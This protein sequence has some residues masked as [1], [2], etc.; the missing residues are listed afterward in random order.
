M[1][2]LAFDVYGTIVDVHGLRESAEPFLGPTASSFLI[3]WRNKT[4]EYAFR[5]GL[6]Q[7]YV[8]FSECS[9]QAL[10]YANTAKSG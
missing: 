10:D 9:R 3:L 5:R 2:V 7:S 4:V 6:M 1:R 8:Q